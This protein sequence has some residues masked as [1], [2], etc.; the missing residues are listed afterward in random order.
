[1]AAPAL[2]AAKKV[3]DSSV[4]EIQSS[5]DLSRVMAR[6]LIEKVGLRVAADSIGIK[7]DALARYVAGARSH[8]GTVK[9]VEDGLKRGE[10]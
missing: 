8:R 1:M 5:D 3:A 2:R 9:L 10:K 6:R 7:P 4:G